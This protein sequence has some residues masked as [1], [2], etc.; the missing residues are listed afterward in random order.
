MLLMRE[1]VGSLTSVVLTSIGDY[2]AGTPA[3]SPSG[4]RLWNGFVHV[5]DGDAKQ[6]EVSSRESAEIG[7]GGVEKWQPEDGVAS[8]KPRL[9]RA[10]YPD[11][12]TCKYRNDAPTGFQHATRRS[13]SPRR[14]ARG[15]TRRRHGSWNCIHGA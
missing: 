4:I 8:G 10:I 6:A 12:N 9:G 5:R 2:A 7:A 14:R 13:A 11:K 15:E 1:A 3:T